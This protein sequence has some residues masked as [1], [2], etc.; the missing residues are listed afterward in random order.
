MKVQ[1]WALVSAFVLAIFTWQSVW[2]E[3]GGESQTLSLPDLSARV[4]LVYTSDGRP[5]LVVLF[6]TSDPDH[7][8]VACVSAHRNLQYVLRDSSG[9]IV[10][11]NPDGWKY[12][13][14]VK[15]SGFGPGGIKDPCANPVAEMQI[16]VLLSDF[17]PKL[18]H[19][20]YTLQITVAP[21]GQSGRAISAPMTVKI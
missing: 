18:S 19:G 9:T 12:P 6:S 3:Q 21:R 15:S 2:A 20:T 13:D 4:H 1:T 14:G 16:R 5:V 17:Y 11:V 8:T 10:P 7:H